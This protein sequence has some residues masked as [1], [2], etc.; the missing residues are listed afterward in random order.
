MHTC[1]CSILYIKDILFQH[2]TAFSIDLSLKLSVLKLDYIK[3]KWLF[4]QSENSNLLGETNQ[5]TE[6][7][8]CPLEF[9]RRN[10]FLQPCFLVQ[11]IS[12]FSQV[13]TNSEET[14]VH[15]QDNHLQ[16]QASSLLCSRVSAFRLVHRICIS[17]DVLLQCMFRL[18]LAMKDTCSGQSLAETVGNCQNA[19]CSSKLQSLSLFLPTKC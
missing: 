11:Q 12:A 6:S 14:P 18:C 16:V 2:F 5:N 4:L 15:S 3:Q 1:I 7:P 9:S 10:P 17:R 19:G 8:F 13:P